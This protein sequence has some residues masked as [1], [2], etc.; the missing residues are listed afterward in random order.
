MIIVGAFAAVALWNGLK[1]TQGAHLLGLES[2]HG[3]GISLPL[4][5]GT[6]C[7]DMRN[8][9]DIY[10][11]GLEQRGDLAYEFSQG[12][13]VDSCDTSDDAWQNYMDV[14]SNYSLYDINHA[15]D[16]IAS[17]YKGGLLDRANV[18]AAAKLLAAP[19]KNSYQLAD[20]N[21]TFNFPSTETKTF[22]DWATHPIDGKCHF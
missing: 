18:C 1:K 12:N 6:S 22:I 9:L 4:Q 15:M 3:P 5:H 13:Y 11:K 7:Q 2:R 10:P 20:Y 19:P 16:G 17:D 21:N 8:W 14:N